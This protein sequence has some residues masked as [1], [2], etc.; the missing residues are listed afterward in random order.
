MYSAA[1]I[2]CDQNHLCWALVF[3]LSAPSCVRSGETGD[4]AVGDI[5][6]TCP[7]TCNSLI[8]AVSCPNHSQFITTAAAGKSSLAN[9]Y[10][11][12]NSSSKLIKYSCHALD[13]YSLTTKLTNSGSPST[14]CLISLALVS[15]AIYCLIVV[16]SGCCPTTYVLYASTSNHDC[17]SYTGE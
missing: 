2:S 3:V 7:Y 5:F 10:I 4:D 13:W 9:Q 11:Y 8:S 16:R 15:N 6:A 12:H 17:K 14:L 1:A